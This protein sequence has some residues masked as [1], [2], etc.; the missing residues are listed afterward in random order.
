MARAIP[1]MGKE[2]TPQLSSL[3]RS[4]EVAEMPAPTQ[5]KSPSPPVVVMVVMV[6]QSRQNWAPQPWPPSVCFPQVFC[7][8]PLVVAAA[9]AA[10]RN[11][12]QK[13]ARSLSQ[14]PPGAMAH[15][16]AMVARCRSAP[17]AAPPRSSPEV[18]SPAAW[19]CKAS[20]AAVAP[21]EVPSPHPPE[22]PIPARSLWGAT[23][24]Q[25][26]TQSRS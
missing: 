13:A 14:L 12:P 19:F 2:S 11:P 16:E 7:C 15:Q 4:E 9:T 8:N 26:E 6:E 10:A 3:S 24:A 20:V 17:W 1:R 5:E 22:G 21:V 23:A 25:E 18:D